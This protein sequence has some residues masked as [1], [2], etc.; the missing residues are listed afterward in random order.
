M[1]Q[2]KTTKREDVVHLQL[3]MGRLQG[4]I[5]QAL[6]AARLGSSVTW[7]MLVEELPTLDRGTA[8]RLRRFSKWHG[9]IL[10]SIEIMPGP[11][12]WQK[13]VLAIEDRIGESEPQ[14]AR[15]R[16]AV[17]DF[18]SAIHRLGGSFEH[19]KRVLQEPGSLSAEPQIAC[20]RQSWFEAAADS[21][22]YSIDCRVE[23]TMLRVNPENPARADSAILQSYIGAHGRPNCSPLVIA[24]QM[25]DGQSDDPRSEARN[26]RACIVPHG[27]SSPPPE[28]LFSSE[29]QAGIAIVQG[30][31]PTRYGS[32]DLSVLRSSS[33]DARV[34]WDGPDRVQ[35]G[36]AI[37]THPT[38][39]LVIEKYLTREYFRDAEIEFSPTRMRGPFGY[40]A[41]WVPWYDRLKEEA[42]VQRFN[43]VS[44]MPSPAGCECYS[45]MM[46]EAFRR[47]GW[48]IDD[49]IPFRVEIEYP[50]PFANYIL[51]F[52]YG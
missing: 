28:I 43:H 32:L 3:A 6:S 7:K 16:A 31:W 49:L 9:D 1:H 15:L 19:A 23:A 33:S 18:V 45:K 17:D 12:A 50:V 25:S 36:H 22:G 38:R 46:T 40:G 13:I 51:A 52:H 2:Q 4:E 20:A 42:T 10:T 26:M 24:Y 44:D 11:R 14:A 47:T 34:P 48:D 41:R 30:D 27:T 39:R 5:K 29:D 35:R 21:M 37:V 8:D